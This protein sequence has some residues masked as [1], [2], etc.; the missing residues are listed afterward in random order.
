MVDGVETTLAH[1]AQ[2]GYTVGT[3]FDLEIKVDGNQI[4]AFETESIY[5]VD[6]LQMIPIQK[7]RLLYI[8]GEIQ[9]TT[10]MMC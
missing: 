10:M 1:V 3:K 4:Q 2:P 6:L 7:E 9:V 8:L 5:L